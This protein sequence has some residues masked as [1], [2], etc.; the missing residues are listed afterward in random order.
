[1]IHKTI[2]TTQGALS[3]FLAIGV[4]TSTCKISNSS[5]WDDLWV[6]EKVFTGSVLGVARNLQGLE[7]APDD[8]ITFTA[9]ART[10]AIGFK[11]CRS[12][13]QVTLVVTQVPHDASESSGLLVQRVFG[14]WR[15]EGAT[16][17][18]LAAATVRSVLLCTFPAALA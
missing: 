17:T 12:L 9:D 5:H 2:Q 3:R 14:V 13:E 4:G 11:L 15:R 18:R 8:T 16:W 7:L 6:K 1:M 10:D